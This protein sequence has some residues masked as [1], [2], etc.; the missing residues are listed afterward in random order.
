MV[1]LAKEA[2]MTRRHFIRLFAL[3]LPFAM[4]GCG[5]TDWADANM[6]VI[7]QRC[8][9]WQCFTSGGQAESQAIHNQRV[10]GDNGEQRRSV[11]GE[12][13]P[14][15]MPQAMAAPAPAA[16]QP[17]ANPMP[18]EGA[19]QYVPRGPSAPGSTPFDGNFTPPE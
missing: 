9:H 4:S 3:T 17:Q 11:N 12:D 19:Y 15:G 16:P 14:G 5:L 13:V 2:R 18:P 10:A 8:E 7:G 1:Q 6:P